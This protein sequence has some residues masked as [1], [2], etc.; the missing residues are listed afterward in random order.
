VLGH[1]A[2]GLGWNDSVERDNHLQRFAPAS[3]G[4]CADIIVQDAADPAMT[5]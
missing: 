4:D 5:G 3:R 1:V 2:L